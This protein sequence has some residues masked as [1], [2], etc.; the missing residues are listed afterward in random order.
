MERVTFSAEGFRFG[1]RDAFFVSGEFHYFRV[2][3]EDWRSRMRAFREAGGNTIATYVPWLIHE[4]QEGTILFDDVPYR[5]LTAFLQI[6]KEEGLQV[7]LRP[8]PYSYSELINSG[9]PPWL[10]DTYDQLMAKNIQGQTFHY[11]TISYLHPLL[12][13]KVRPFFRAF[14]D[15]VRPFMAENGGPVC[16]LQVDNE[17]GGV[18]IWRGSLDYNRE[19]M[20]I[21]VPGGRYPRFLEK[22]F[23]TV[24]ALNEFYGTTFDSFA[25]VLPVAATDRNDVFSCRRSKDYYD[26]YCGTLAEFAALLKAWM[27][28]DGL[29]GPF[30]HNAANP[31]MNSMF[32]ETVEAMGDGFL[33]G[34]DHYYTLNHSW[35][36][37]NPT[38]RYAIRVFCSNELLRL[39]GM[40]PTVLEMPGG[41]PSDTPPILPQDLLACYQ[42]NLAMGMKGMN[43]YVYTGGPNVQG[44]GATCDIYDYNALIRAD[45]SKN[46]TFRVLEE[47]GTFLAANGWMQK[48]AL[49]SSVQVGFEWAATRAQ[50][51]DYGKQA[52]PLFASWEFMQHGIL[53]GLFCSSHLPQLQPLDRPLDLSKPLLIPTASAMSQDAQE[54]IIRFVEAGGHAIL[55]GAMPETDLDYR[56]CEALKAFCGNPETVKLKPRDLV[57]H[58]PAMATTVYN[59]EAVAGI[60]SVP[61][62]AEP[63]VYET[64]EQVCMGYRLRK[65][66]GSITW[67]SMKFMTRTFEQV[68]LL[69]WL[70]KEAGGKALIRSENRNVM[71][72][73]WEGPDGKAMLFAMNL[74]SSPQETS[75]TVY[76]GTEKQCELGKISLGAMEVK[77]I[78]L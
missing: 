17:M 21:G 23:G 25:S 27:L 9:M 44:T 66:S 51:Q 41:S 26:F 29:S 34:S 12:L 15:V 1:D 59:M 38:P 56:P 4:P 18:H 31:G 43:I 50:G 13:E 63:I 70:L 6:A 5:D 2:P 73:L 57:I 49:A 22:K 39:M 35:A 45:G 60:A 67:L 24:A 47:F 7:V 64:K 37:N 61:A 77:T 33:L 53:Y 30:C 46:A 8:G 52:M 3:K 74:Y 48:A 14:A 75:V 69:E 42:S 76:P 55:I 58:V 36:Q 54:N 32:L 68:S 20:G 16:M 10:V 62:G 11:D 65:G 72:T 71:T 19:T 28:E 78:L 40:P